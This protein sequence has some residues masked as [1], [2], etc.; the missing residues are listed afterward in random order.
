MLERYREAVRDGT[1]AFPLSELLGFHLTAV[2]PGEAV[3]EL[4]ARDRHSNPMGTLHGGVLATI[5]DT[6]MAVAHSSLLPEGESGATIEM[7]INF[8]RPFWQGKLRATGK[9]IKHGRSLTYLESEV[10]DEDGALIARASSTCM[11]L[12]GEAAEGG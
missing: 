5:A 12:R 2:E 4:E 8:L 6:S 1:Y 9:A 7:K 10:H 3:I 11:T